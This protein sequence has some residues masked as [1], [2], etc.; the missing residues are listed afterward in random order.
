MARTRFCSSAATFALPFNTRETVAVDTPAAR[1]TSA[2]E[3]AFDF[4]RGALFFVSLV[5]F[6]S[7]RCRGAPSRRPFPTYYNAA[8]RDEANAGR[9]APAACFRLA[10]MT[11]GSML[12]LANR[13]RG[14]PA[15]R[16]LSR[17]IV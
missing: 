17:V 5:N 14:T 15:K 7:A 8:L 1:A 16:S 2:T 11:R 3:V 13:E 4:R 10:N 12:A 6:H 9:D